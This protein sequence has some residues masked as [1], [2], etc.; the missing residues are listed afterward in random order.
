M[1]RSLTGSS[2]VTPLRGSDTP[3]R[4]PPH[5]YEAEQALLGAI[6]ANNRVFDRVD[7]FLRPEHFADAAARPHLR[8]DRQAD[9]ARP[10]RQPRSP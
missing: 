5:N 10:D 8:G 6:L 9:P 7:E 3:P 2:N 4:V 1:E